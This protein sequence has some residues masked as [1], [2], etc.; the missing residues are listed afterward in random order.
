MKTVEE[1]EK[2]YK[3]FKTTGPEIISSTSLALTKPKRHK[4]KSD[5]NIMFI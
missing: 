3:E 2:E 4:N 5:V 1:I